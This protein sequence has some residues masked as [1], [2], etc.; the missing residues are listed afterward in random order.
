MGNPEHLA[1]LKEGVEAW[2]A[3]RGKT[4]DIMPD[5]RGANLCEVD[6]RGAKCSSPSFLAAFLVEVRKNLLEVCIT[7]F[8]PHFC[9]LRLVTILSVEVPSG[10]SVN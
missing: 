2:N 9:L 7:Y 6:L 4:P 8:N 1:K 5:L 3:W 10:E